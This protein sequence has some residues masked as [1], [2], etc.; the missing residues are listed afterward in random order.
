MLDNTGTGCRVEDEVSSIKADISKSEYDG[1]GYT[2]SDIVTSEA[3]G[4]S[5]ADIPNSDKIITPIKAA[6]GWGNVPDKSKKVILP[7]NN[8]MTR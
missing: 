2:P 1:Y 7:V 6:D 8:G 5:S 3:D 4:E